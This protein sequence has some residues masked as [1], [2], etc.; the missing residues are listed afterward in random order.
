MRRLMALALLALLLPAGAWAQGIRYPGSAGGSATAL[1]I[2]AVPAATTG[3]VEEVLM[4]Y[5]IPANFF[6]A[7]GKGLHFRVG[8]QVAANGNTKTLRVRIGGIGGAIVASQVTA[9]NATGGLVEGYVLRDGA[10]TAR[11]AA[12]GLISTD[13]I[14][15]TIQATGL[16]FTGAIDLVVTGETGSAAGDAT[17]NFF[18]VSTV[19]Q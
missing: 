19:N 11:A 18:I 15:T 5:S 16:T 13:R 7:V 2:N 10:T 1:H 4:T 8:T 3:T 6:S 12:H 17:A 9:T 14:G